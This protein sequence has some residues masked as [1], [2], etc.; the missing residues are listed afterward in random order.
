LQDCSTLATPLAA[1]VR[2]DRGEETVID[3]KLFTEAAIASATKALNAEIVA[4]LSALPDP[5][6]FPAETVRQRRREGLGPFPS[7]PPSE[8]A[9]TIEIPG[10]AGPIA[11]RIIAP[12]KPRG[13]YLH[14]HGGGWTWGAPDE[15]DTDRE[16]LA[17]RGFASVSVRY[18]LAPE[19][20]YPAAPDDCEAAA[21]WFAREAEAMFGTS[22]FAIGGESAGAH[23]ALVTMLRLRD[24]HGLTPF[25]GA[26]LFAGCYDLGMSPSVRN[27]GSEK[28]ILNTRDITLFTQNFC[29]DHDRR[30][31]DLSP[32]YADLAGLPRALISVGTRDLLLDDS[33]FMA[34]R[35]SA[36]GIPVDLAVWPGGCHVFQRFDF[37]MAEEALAR[38]DGFFDTL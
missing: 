25:A 38:I 2:N 1:Q 34:A 24:R 36:A 5:W 18:R 16:R 23:L 11:L 33:L 26:N 10:P 15:H 30:D 7:P 19:H 14:I 27:W 21:L 9:R 8:R 12:E 4:R 13:V 29:L 37:P 31:P 17:E 6:S 35:M 32:L 22:L 20:P 3:P 28:L